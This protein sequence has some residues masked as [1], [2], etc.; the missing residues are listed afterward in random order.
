MMTYKEAEFKAR[1]LKAMAHPVRLIIVDLLR[2]G[3]LSF[4]ELKEKFPF[5]KSTIS[6]HLAI[7]RDVGIVSSRRQGMDMVYKL[8]IPCALDFLECATRV[9]EESIER[10]CSCL[11]GTGGER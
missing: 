5:D 9:L 3:E 10:Q 1:I 4:S 11:W 6:K 8:E 2:E 7:L